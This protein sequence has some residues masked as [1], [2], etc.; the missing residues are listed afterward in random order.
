MRHLFSLA[1]AGDLEG[2][3]CDMWPFLP[4]R[5]KNVGDLEGCLVL[6]PP[7]PNHFTLHK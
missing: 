1:S 6:P 7:P 2:S 5:G 4:L 3:T